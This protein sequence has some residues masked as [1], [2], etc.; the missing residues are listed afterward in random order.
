MSVI[1][2]KDV[3]LSYPNGFQ[4]LKALSVRIEPGEFV[5]VIGR[6]GA[7]KST[8]LKAINRT[9]AVTSGEAHVLEYDL[10]G[11][12]Q[13]N[14]KELRSRIGFIFQ[15]FNLVKNLT[16]LDNVKHGRLAKVGLLRSLLN[17]YPEEDIR[18]AKEA[19]D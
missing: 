7:G 10:R 16:A 12:N 8:L 13:R 14:L 17:F 6:S 18:L 15:Q 9:V 1:S 4:A 19:L 11:L 3:G 5:A 2:F